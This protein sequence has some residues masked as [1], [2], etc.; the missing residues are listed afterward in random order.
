MAF[1]RNKIKGRSGLIRGASTGGTTST[2]STFTEMNS[3][4]TALEMLAYPGAFTFGAM[5]QSFNASWTDDA[6]Y[7][8][9]LVDNTWFRETGST[10]T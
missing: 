6:K 10:T 5:T 1:T 8:T 3:S 4:T 2:T 9:D 7:D